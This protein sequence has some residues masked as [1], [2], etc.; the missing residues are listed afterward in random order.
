MGPANENNHHHN[1]GS[2]REPPFRVCTLT[3]VVAMVDGWGLDWGSLH[4]SIH[5]FLCV[6]NVGRGATCNFAA[7]VVVAAAASATDTQ[8]QATP[9]AEQNCRRWNDH[10]PPTGGISTF[11]Q[12]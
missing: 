8:H 1:Q 7:A 11:A 4:S 5:P 9:E 3:V 2:R 12:F 6:R 10:Y